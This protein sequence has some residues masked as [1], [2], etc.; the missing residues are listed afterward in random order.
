MANF[1]NRN[2]RITAQLHINGNKI[3]KTF[4]SKVEANLWAAQKEYDH[5]M[6][7]DSTAGETHTFS[8]VLD[9][10]QKAFVSIQKGSR[11]VGYRIKKIKEQPW[12]KLKLRDL[13]IEDL[14]NYRDT[15][16][17]TI[18][19]KTMQDEWKLIKLAASKAHVFDIS[20]PI[21]IF[22]EIVLPRVFAPEI[23]RVTHEDVAALMKGIEFDKEGKGVHNNYLRPLI[24][25]ALATA[26]RRGE[27][28]S[29]EWSD[30]D[31]ASHWIYVRQE[32]SKTGYSRKIPITFEAESALEEFKA[33]RG[34]SGYVVKATAS[35]VSNSWCRL[36]KRVGLAHIRF[37]DLRHEAISRLHEYQ[38]A[39]TIPEIQSISGHRELK[40]LERYSHANVSQLA[41]KMRGDSHAN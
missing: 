5:Y 40:M 38:P 4:A 39:L 32:K 17:K 26:L 19:P 35:G 30:V 34:D 8:D 9:R 41:T 7:Y 10:Y 3:A 2:G 29:L 33:V 28:V 25:L 21:G 6:G 12:T 36:K 20:V 24:K 37:H 18:K 13:R 22:K 31:M 15:R 27:L 11:N 1:R 14:V 16:L 23:K